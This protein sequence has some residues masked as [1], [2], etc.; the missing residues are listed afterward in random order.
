MAAAQRARRRL[1]GNAAIE[2]LFGTAIIVIVAVLGTLPPAQP[3]ASTR[4]PA[5]SPPMRRSSISTAKTAWRT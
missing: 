3:S 1:L 5:P 2:A 4:T